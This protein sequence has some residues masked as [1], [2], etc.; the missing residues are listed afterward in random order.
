[1]A[2]AGE[3]GFDKH[4]QRALPNV[5]APYRSCA[6]AGGGGTGGGRFAPGYLETL[7]PLSMLESCHHPVNENRTHGT[8][9]GLT[10]LYV[11]KMH[12]STSVN[13]VSRQVFFSPV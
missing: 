1:M 7:S 5:I 3:P 12:V 8:P 6:G 4:T 11:F 2:A 13:Y 10:H 9:P